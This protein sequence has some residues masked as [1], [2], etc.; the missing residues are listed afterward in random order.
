MVA[1]RLLLIEDN[2]D[3]ALLVVRNLR[4]GG[5]TVD[6]ERVE[7]AEAMSTALSA[8]PPDIVISDN[9]MPA[10]DAASALR[11][12]RDRQLD[13]PFIVVSG[14][15][16]EET[17][18][19]LMRA[20]AHDFVLKD[21]LARL[22]P[23]VG[24]ELRE[25]GERQ[26]KRRLERELHQVERL[27]SLG[28]L[29]G[30]IAHDFNNLLGVISGSAEF[31]LELL[32]P[33]HAGRA[34]VQNIDDA[35]RMAAALTRQLLIFSRL[36]P[37]Q[38]EVLDVGSVVAG[39][40]R[41]LR[42]TIGADIEFIV[43]T[44]PDLEQVTIDR[45]RLEQIILNLVVNARAAMPDGG[46]LTISAAAA[47]HH[48]TSWR[49]PDSPHGRF[50]RLS[51]DDTGIGMSPEV[52]E[53]AFQPFFTT[54]DPGQGTGLG[55]AT[56][57]G[58]VREAGGTIS[59]ESEPGKGTRVNIYLPSVPRP[60]VPVPAACSAEAGHSS[61]GEHILVVDDNEA[62]RAISKRILIRAGYRVTEASTRDDAVRLGS[63]AD[64][65]LDMVLA[66]VVM[67][68]LTA[69]EMIDAIRAHRPEISVALMSGH[70]DPV[71]VGRLLTDDI[72][73]IAK[74]FDTATLLRE[75]RT[76]IDHG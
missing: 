47:D 72:P 32:G 48:D 35:A 67:P 39:T 4:S 65:E 58:A 56:A 70:A 42:R 60:A 54:K 37:S 31:L 15:I 18:V 53:Q 38:P 14:Q 41:L 24:R 64:L 69:Y 66:D 10:F 27:D 9:T 6:Y 63:D 21:S 45:S 52:M 30:G 11:L 13:V 73:I 16:G 28:Q 57:Y 46:R 26:E 44:Q 68:G 1:V 5:L 62:L 43:Q 2:E 23:A 20:G 25:A 22:L 8:R 51:V 3:D 29:A 17:A 76:A 71:R 12:L 74:P 75:V 33:A 19:A 40:E 36:Q 61:K 34:D 59:L 50:V 55:L 49:D 7:T